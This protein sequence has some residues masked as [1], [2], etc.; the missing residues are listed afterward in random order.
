MNAGLTVRLLMPTFAIS[1]VMLVESAGQPTRKS[2]RPVE[3]RPPTSSPEL[4]RTMSEPGGLEPPSGVVTLAFAGDMHFED[5][6][7]DLLA[8]P[9]R[10]LGPITQ[11]LKTADLAMVNLESAITNRGVPEA[12]E[13]EE[14]SQRFH[15]RT[16]PAALTF[17]A[18][19]G[20]DVVTMGNNH[21]A[22]FGPVGLRDTF[23]AIRRSPIP[24]VGV[25]VDRAEAF[26]PHRVRI[27]QT[28]FA[29]FGA[30]GATREGASS[31]W[32]AG[33]TNPGV[34]AAR[35]SR[36]RLLLEAVRRASARDDVVVVY[37]H[38]GVEGR[39]CPTTKQQ[40]TAEALAEAGADIIVGSH[41]HLLMP[42]ER[43]GDTYVNYG[44]GNFLWY[45][46]AQAASGVLKVRI[47]DGVVTTDSWIPARI[48]EQGR[49]IPLKGSTRLKAIK[50]WRELPLCKQPIPAGDSSATLP[51]YSSSVAPIDAS[52][53]AR[54]RFSHRPGC[55][56]ALSDLRYLRM[57]FVGFDGKHHTGEMVVHKDHVTDVI[58]VFG[59]LYAE[60]WPIE[61]MTLID[62]FEGD[63]DRS[64]TANNTSGFNCRNVAGTERWSEHSYGAA[65]DINPLQNPYVSSTSIVPPEGVA[66][67]N[68]LRSPGAKVKPGVI[69]DS[70]VV[71][72][73]FGSV[74]WKWGGNWL[75]SKDY[76]H[77]S[78]S[79][80]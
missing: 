41:T 44:L 20:I 5:E 70:D 63:D 21:A 2:A 1:L 66:N 22:D 52:L 19:A 61:Q 28:D 37:L 23:E 13:L 43:L 33:L 36:P 57:A 12:K 74:G 48:S 26:A 69:K 11:I 27:S 7:G 29:F 78:V 49:P 71:V 25:G 77:F 10:S 14:P 9:D 58:D 46:N 30:D 35:E 34:A 15:F 54:M 45:H 55:P 80:R 6:L 8:E 79:G 67:A 64:M 56:V 73:A 76:Q 39:A 75:T 60:R 4:D 51:A 17:L 62:T 50:T 38:W 40:I 18:D 59:K 32:A 31:V 16:S 72:R 53:R 42:S 3:A 47:E 24:V 65:I 68:V